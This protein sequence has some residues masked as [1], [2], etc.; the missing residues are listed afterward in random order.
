MEIVVFFVKIVESIKRKRR[1]WEAVA[2]RLEDTKIWWPLTGREMWIS[3]VQ[4]ELLPSSRCHSTFLLR[5]MLCHDKKEFTI[6]L[7]KE[8]KAAANKGDFIKYIT[9][10]SQFW[11]RLSWPCGVYYRLRKKL[12]NASCCVRV[13]VKSSSS[14]LFIIVGRANA[15]VWQRVKL[16]VW[17]TSGQLTR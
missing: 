14:Y 4:L 6:S 7:V 13:L 9:A 3:Q 2:L 16:N 11:H 17:L 12:R 8:T 15:S 10:K 1:F 5:R